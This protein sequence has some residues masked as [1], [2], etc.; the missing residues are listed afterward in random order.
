MLPRVLEPEVME[1]L[2]EALDYNEMDHREVNERFVTDLID[3][4]GGVVEGDVLDVGTGTALIPIELC[5][6]CEDCRIMA[7]DMAISM[8]DIARLN[9][10]IANLTCR[11]QLGRI[12]AKEL[13]FPDDSFAIV[14]SNSIVHHIPEPFT[15]LR[16]ALRV[17]QP[18]GLLFFR[19]LIRPASD[20]ELTRLVETYAGDEKEHARQMFA[21][22]LRAALTLD[23]V[24]QGVADLGFPPQ[25][26]TATSDRHWTWTARKPLPPSPPT[27]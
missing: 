10:E 18:G 22:S 25:S 1:S 4:A 14:M 19:D 8:L 2:E 24:R 13:P 16:E 27:T 26:V 20:A 9:L 15:V 11:V 12:D 7:I 17:T 6:R 3:A 23:E 5:R 21:D